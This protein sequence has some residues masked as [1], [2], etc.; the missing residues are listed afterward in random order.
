M[1]MT[2]LMLLDV[3]VILLA[4]KLAGAMLRR[5]GQPAVI[6]EI[7]VGIL[8]GPTLLSGA[9]T[10]VMLPGDVQAALRA[11]ATVGL[12][13]FMFTVGYELDHR[14]LRGRVRAAVGIALG[15][16]LVPLALGA[17]LA[18]WLALTRYH[19]AN[20]WLFVLFIGVSMSVT[21]LPVL[22]SIIADRGLSGTRVGGLA[23][24]GAAVVD[25]AAWTLL[26]VIVAL[27]GGGSLWQI[28]L[29]VPYLLV[30]VLGVRRLLAAFLPRWTGPGGFATV[31]AGL[32][33]SAAVTEW[34]G[35]HFVFGALLFGAIL[36]GRDSQALSRQIE[37]ITRV[38]GVLL[39]PV[40]FVVS[41]L[42]VDL[43]GLGA[44]GVGELAM[45]LVVAVGA[46]VGGTYLGA[47]LCGVGRRDAGAVSV[48]MNARGVTEIVVLRVGLEIGVLDTRLYSLLVL[49]ALLT[50][51]LT[52]PL[53]ML[54]ERRAGRI[55]RPDA[56]PVPPTL[57][58]ASRPTAV[59]E[60]ERVA[61]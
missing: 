33:L 4:G 45:I 2:S 61:R 30:M 20:M 36:P 25:G 53:L 5:I 17:G 39:L 41:G 47:R 24:A 22:A 31:V 9:I 32:F 55:G 49:M 56:A 27:A 10:R 58:H 23:V 12:V 37:E 51:A 13:L 28:L 59:E 11:V 16:T 15:S 42:S 60:E 48:L 57:P 46:K 1:T 21:A 38:C 19:P 40:F 50:T 52:G 26:A 8:L 44:T 34:L 6:G 14:M 54:I 7:T 3:A 43:S 29:I 18:T 35:M